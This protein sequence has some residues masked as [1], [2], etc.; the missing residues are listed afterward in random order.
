MHARLSHTHSRLT[1]STSPRNSC[2]VS[3]SGMPS[4][5]SMRAPSPCGMAYISASRSTRPL[6]DAGRSRPTDGCAVAPTGPGGV[7]SA[8]RA[9]AT[10]PTTAAHRSCARVRVSAVC[11]VGA[12]PLVEC[13]STPSRR[14]HSAMRLS[15][16][17]SSDGVVGAHHPHRRAS[18]LM[19]YGGS[20]NRRRAS[21][22]SVPLC[23]RGRAAPSSADRSL[24][25]SARVPTMC[26]LQVR[27]RNTRA[28]SPPRSSSPSSSRCVQH[29][30]A[31]M[32]RICMRS[33]D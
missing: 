32:T 5:G 11:V 7:M 24:R 14:G 15:R 31:V 28:R 8:S 13:G 6:G 18:M 23:R 33:A 20:A 1:M 22:W 30:R 17:D 10:T 4:D 3:I 19:E 26:H 12:V 25:D 27:I 9:A 16:L 2:S 21:V 29:R